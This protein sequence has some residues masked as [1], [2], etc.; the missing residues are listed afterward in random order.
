MNPC[1][2]TNLHSRKTYQFKVMAS[3]Q[4]GHSVF[5]D[6]VEGQTKV[7]FKDIPIPFEAYYD[8]GKFSNYITITSL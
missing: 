8:N 4:K 5:S 1:K 7:S 6:V 2:L 3:N